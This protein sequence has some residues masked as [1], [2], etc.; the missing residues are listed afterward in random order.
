MQIVVDQHVHTIVLSQLRGCWTRRNFRIF[1]VIHGQ[2]YD[3]ERDE[4]KIPSNRLR[5]PQRP[6]VDIR[7]DVR[8]FLYD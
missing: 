7:L 5:K 2:R 1:T 8:F 4:R 3:H 6:A